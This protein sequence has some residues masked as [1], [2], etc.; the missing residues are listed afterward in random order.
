[1]K[2]P[3][4]KLTVRQA[5]ITDLAYLS[6]NDKH[7][8]PDM[9]ARKVEQGAVMILRADDVYGG[10]LR[11][12]YFWDSIPFMNM[13]HIHKK[14]RGHGCGRMLVSAWE[15]AM[16]ATGYDL[17]MTST[18]ADEQAQYFY[19]KLGYVDTGALLLPDEATELIFRKHLSPVKP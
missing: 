18:L 14:L 4:N 11:W 6:A 15:Q 2:Q 12:G 3:A 17:V 10:W 13:L 1:M 19:R 9:M 5:D 16:H 8:S 7:I